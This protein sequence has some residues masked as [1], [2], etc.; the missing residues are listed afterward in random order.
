M[1]DSDGSLLGLN[2]LALTP[3][4]AV[5]DLTFFSANTME[6]MEKHL[7]SMNK[8]TDEIKKEYQSWPGNDGIKSL[9]VAAKN[10]PVDKDEDESKDELVND[11][12]LEVICNSAKVKAYYAKKFSTSE[13]KKKIVEPMVGIKTMS[14]EVSFPDAYKG[15]DKQYDNSMNKTE[16]VKTLAKKYGVEERVLFAFLAD[17]EGQ[18]AEVSEQITKKDNTEEGGLKTFSA[19]ISTLKNELAKLTADKAKSDR[20]S[21]IDAALR[22]G[23]VITLSA[24]LHQTVDLNVLADII[25]NAPKSVPTAPKLQILSA[26]D[27]T[28]KESRVNRSKSFFASQASKIDSAIGR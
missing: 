25:K 6:E 3:N 8:S 24:E 28:T 17:Y 16:N 1:L 2:S 22:D 19:E 7:T 9:A 15:Q 12:N 13:D 10:N 4:G 18:N 21:M 26:N 11:E 5:K 27:N 14:A 23:K 20:K